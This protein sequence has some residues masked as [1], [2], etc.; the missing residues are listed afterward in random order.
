MYNFDKQQPLL[1]F[2]RQELNI[3]TESIELA[4]RH[5]DLP[6]SSLPML[7]WGYGLISLS[8]LERIFD[9]LDH[10]WVNSVKTME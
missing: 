9:W 7:L 10:G 4:Q 6:Y 5:P 1:E 8:Q 2:L 3:P